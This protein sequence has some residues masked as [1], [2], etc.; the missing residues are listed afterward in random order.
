MTCL[1]LMSCGRDLGCRPFSLAVQAAKSCSVPHLLLMCKERG[2]KLHTGRC[3]AC[4][5]ESLTRHACCCCAEE[6]A[7]QG[8]SSPAE[9]P[10]CCSGACTARQGPGSRWQGGRS[11]AEGPACC[12]GMH[13]QRE[14]AAYQEGA[15]SRWRQGESACLHHNSPVPQ[16]CLQPQ[17]PSAAPRT[18]PEDSLM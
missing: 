11:P 3:G 6:W 9:G 18:T 7:R 17:L 15:D 12:G 2:H 10:A 16:A 8:P 5:A 14:G 1:L 13:L 4:T